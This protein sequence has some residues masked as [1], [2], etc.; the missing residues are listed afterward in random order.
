MV[1]IYTK[2]GDNGKT[3]LVG[4]VFL[5]KDDEVFD[6]IGGIDELN[7]SLGIVKS[8][9]KERVLV[10]KIEKIQNL[11]FH[12]SSEVA[13]KKKMRKEVY[14]IDEVD[15]ET[16]E[17]EIDKWEEKLPPLRNFLFP[18]NNKVS[19]FV[20]YSR[21]VCRRTERC[22]IKYS[23]KESMRPQILVFVNRLSD[24]LFVLARVTSPEDDNIWT[25]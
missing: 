12:L 25:A 10:D 4:D 14:L 7:A 21:T 18:G 8:F 3:S 23:R 9:L 17:K 19:S 5:N 13:D 2:L 24:W 22:I 16:L 11:L 15:V 1:R 20:H 6:V